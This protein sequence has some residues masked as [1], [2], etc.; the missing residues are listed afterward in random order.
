MTDLTQSARL[1]RIAGVILGTAVGDA[2][3]VPREGLSRRRARR[4]FGDPPLQH[5]FV[6]GR[7]MISDDTE[8][9]C[10]TGQALLRSP[11]D[12]E[13]FARSLAWGLRCWLLGMPAGI[14]RATLRAILKLWLG[15]P[16]ARSGVW[17][18][19][20]GPAMRAALLGVCLDG[21]A[22]RDYVRASTR[23]THTDPRAEQGALL[24]AL[25][26]RHGLE[27][28]AAGVNGLE[29]L[30]ARMDEQGRD[31]PE[32]QQSLLR[33]AE[34]L[35]RNAPAAELADALGLQAG[36]SGYIYHTVP[37]CLYCW[38][39]WP[40]DFRRAVEEVIALGGDA[41]TTGAIVG[42]IAG[43]TLGAQGIPSEWLDGLLDWPCSGAWMQ[44]L[45]A[46][47]AEQFP[48]SGSGTG[49]GPVSFCWPGL[50]PRNLAF[51]ALVLLHAGRRLLPPY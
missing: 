38:L 15:F 2:L 6:L 44:T 34:H 10:L 14:G 22:L 41:D 30:Q 39:R 51:L 28:G 13:R 42:G 16:P 45:A 20:N 33:L 35:Q 5:A 18:A 46:R 49:D 47:L 8:H 27:R 4:L 19:G 17:S 25:A 32:L 37:L 29:F 31:D 23:L 26:G 9:T 3:G 50:L 43:A 36:V 24:V 1:D 48:A 12:P 7:G 21:G 40:G 11:A